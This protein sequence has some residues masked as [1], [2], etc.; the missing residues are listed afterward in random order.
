MN[1]RSTTLALTAAAAFTVTACGSE[2]EADIVDVAVVE[3]PAPMPELAPAPVVEEAEPTPERAAE[4]EEAANV[5]PADALMPDEMR[6]R[7]SDG[8]DDWDAVPYEEQ[9]GFGDG[10]F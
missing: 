2:E 3:E 4:P 8:V 10:N 9:D 5:D 1:L 6:Y 7:S